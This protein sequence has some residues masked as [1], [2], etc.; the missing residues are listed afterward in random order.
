MKNKGWREIPQAQCN[1]RQRGGGGGRI[2]TEE[3][4]QRDNNIKSPHPWTSALL[5]N[6]SLQD[7]SQPGWRKEKRH[8]SWIKSKGERRYWLQ[9]RYIFASYLETNYQYELRWN[10]S[11]ARHEQ[12]VARKTDC[13]KRS[14]GAKINFW[15]TKPFD[16]K[17]RQIGL[18]MDCTDSKKARIWC[19]PPLLDFKVLSY[20]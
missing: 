14:R 4:K 20:L 3:L 16:C 10:K 9:T 7:M 18:A 12:V 15:L 19:G 5:M 13:R 2:I 11:T 6:V 17:I 1:T 8:L